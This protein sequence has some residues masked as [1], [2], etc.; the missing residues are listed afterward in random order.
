MT[1]NDII[2]ALECKTECHCAVCDMKDIVPCEHCIFQYIKHALD[3]INRQKEEIEQLNHKY[4]LAVAEREANVK[5]FA[6]ALSRLK[7]EAIK[8]FAEKLKAKA[9]TQYNGFEANEDRVIKLVEVDDID[10]LVKEM[11]GD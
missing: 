9:F 11:V 6:D 5:G 3:L 10:K 1:D 2:K 4:E 7:A 8:K